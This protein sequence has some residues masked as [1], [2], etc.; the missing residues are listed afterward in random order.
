MYPKAYFFNIIIFS[1]HLTINDL[2][3]SDN[4]LGFS[5]LQV[6]QM[7]ENLKPTIL[8]LVSSSIQPRKD[9]SYMWRIYSEASLYVCIQAPTL[10]GWV[11]LGK[12]PSLCLIFLLN[13]IGIIRVLISR[14]LFYIYMSQCLQNPLMASIQIAPSVNVSYCQRSHLS[15]IQQ[16]LNAKPLNI[17]FF[18]LLSIFFLLLFLQ[19]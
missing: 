9:E 14:V 10:T 18:I 1:L 17:I 11:A 3:V 2:P 12:L 7:M 6:E 8:D 15:Y 19:L 5:P 13:E 4:I 16:T